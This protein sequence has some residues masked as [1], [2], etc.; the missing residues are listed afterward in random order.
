MTIAE[1]VA[2]LAARGFVTLGGIADVEQALE[3][4][5]QAEREACR[6]IAHTFATA[7][8]ENEKKYFDF[9]RG[10]C[11]IAGEIERSIRE[12]TPKAPRSSRVRKVA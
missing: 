10:G 11:A 8:T 4:A 9:V 2:D 5:A 6:M 3:D 12:R 1:T 7:A